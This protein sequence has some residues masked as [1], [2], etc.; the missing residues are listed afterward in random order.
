IEAKGWIAVPAPT[1]VWAA[2]ETWLWTTTPS[3]RTTSRPISEKAPTRTSAP[4]RAPSSMTA[5]GWML[6][7]KLRSLID[8]HGAD[9]SLCD[10]DPRDDAVALELPDDAARTR[11]AHVIFEH[12]ARH[13]R[14]AELRAIDRH[15]VDDAW[16]SV[17]G[18][19]GDADRAGR[20]CH[21]LEDQH[22][23]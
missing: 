18:G 3:P 22:A 16:R 19:V 12:V 13:H 17:L 1:V 11:L 8:Q 7:M 14:L 10:L 23:R 5:V 21:A 20:L 15:Q 2:I 9:L 6:L 4:R